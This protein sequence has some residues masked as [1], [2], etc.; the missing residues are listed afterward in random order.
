MLLGNETER[1]PRHSQQLRRSSILILIVIVRIVFIRIPSGPS[2]PRVPVLTVLCCAPC[3]LSLSADRAS[4]LNTAQWI[5]DVRSE[6]GNDVVIMLVGNKGD[7]IDK[8]CEHNHEQMDGRTDRRARAGATGREFRQRRPWEG[9]R[10]RQ[11]QRHKSF[12]AFA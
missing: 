1:N 8:R 4:F 6:R 7:L 5:D 2:N 12:T 11:Q 3:R 9:E 10:K